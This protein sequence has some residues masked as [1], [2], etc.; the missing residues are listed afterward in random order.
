MERDGRL[1]GLVTDG[2]IRRAV[3]AIGSDPAGNLRAVKAEAMMTRNPITIAPNVLAFEALRMME[4]RPSQISVLPVTDPADGR[5]LGL[6]RI[7][8]I[9]R[10]GL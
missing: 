7:H 5:C 4:D 3:H 9:L 8:D 10:S 6:L 2:D 1:I